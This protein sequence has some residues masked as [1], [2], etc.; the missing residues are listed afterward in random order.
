VTGVLQAGLAFW[1]VFSSLDYMTRYGFALVQPVPSAVA[2]HF[3]RW[4]PGSLL[5]GVVFAAVFWV[6]LSKNYQ[7]YRRERD[8]GD[9]AA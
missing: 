2:W 4:L 8:S 9:D 6:V 1:A 7:A 5:V 3:A